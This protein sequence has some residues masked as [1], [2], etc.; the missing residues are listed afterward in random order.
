LE[1]VAISF[2]MMNYNYILPALILT[3][4]R[5]VFRAFRWRTILGPSI[6]TSVWGLFSPMMIGCLGNFLPVRAAEVLRPFLLSKKFDFSF[7]AAFASIVIER[8][9]DLIFLTLI[10]AW[11]FW[12]KADYISPALEFAGMPLQTM[13]VKFGQISIAAI[14]ILMISIYLLLRHKEKMTCTIRWLTLI[15]PVKWSKK[16]DLIIKEF[17]AG[18]EV[19]K[20]FGALIQ[21][22]IYSALAWMANIFSVYPLYLAFD[23]ENK[24]VTS[25]LVLTIMVA[26]LS[27][28]APTP[29]FLGSYN[30]G[31]FIALHEIMNESEAK[32]VSFGIVG[33]ALYICVVLG[34]GLYFLFCEH[35][36]FRTLFQKK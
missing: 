4:L 10:F 30:A 1:E 24:T 18:C 28:I 26:I 6:K 3:A 36:S 19:I 27:T 21:I 34:S 33:W 17:S 5:Y 2:K 13:A 15:L 12:F 16:V 32:A 29:G 22:T 11:I 14:L 7:S 31:V 9:F 25:L 20:S 23:L 35:I 8:L